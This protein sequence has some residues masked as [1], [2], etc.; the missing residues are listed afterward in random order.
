MLSEKNN[1]IRTPLKNINLNNGKFQIVN[2]ELEYSGVGVMYLV[3]D[4]KV[5]TDK[6]RSK[7][8]FKR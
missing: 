3:N 7:D 2:F 4:P 1:V 6:V 5:M 8:I